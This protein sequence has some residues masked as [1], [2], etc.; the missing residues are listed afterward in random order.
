LD[1]QNQCLISQYD[2]LGAD[3]KRTLNNNYADH[4]GLV[5]SFLAYNATR[6]HLLIPGLEHW[7]RD[8]LFFIQY[9]RMKCSKSTVEYNVSKPFFFFK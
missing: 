2:A 5:A 7:S 8:Q 6:N 4:G 1:S 9:A 3:G